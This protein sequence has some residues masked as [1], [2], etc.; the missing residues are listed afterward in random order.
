MSVSELVIV[1]GAVVM[2]HQHGGMTLFVT[3]VM[4]SD[5]LGGAC[6]GAIPERLSL[7]FARTRVARAR[8]HAHTQ[9]CTLTHTVY[10]RNRQQRRVYPIV[11]E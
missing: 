7:C 5:S 10:C 3:G 2:Y 6:A 1:K 9:T 11:V 4:D 8:T